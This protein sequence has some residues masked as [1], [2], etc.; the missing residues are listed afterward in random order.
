MIDFPTAFLGF[1]VCLLAWCSPALADHHASAAPLKPFTI[2][3]FEFPPLLHSTQSGAF[4]G[5]MGESVKL[6]CEEA[7]LDCRFR[8]VPLKRA[9]RELKENQADALITIDLGQLKECCVASK[10]ASPWSAGWFAS[11]TIERIPEKE[12]D[13]EEQ[14]LI[15][16][17]GMKSPYRF[18]PNLDKMAAEQKLF[19]SK[20][21]DISASVQ[22]FIHGRAPLLW[23]GEDFK[24]YFRKIDPT[25]QFS[26]TSKITIP[27]VVWARKERTA[28][29]ERLNS[30]F[31]RLVEKGL[32][33]V[34][35]L[36]EPSLMGQ[37]YQDAPFGK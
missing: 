5:T 11:P 32:L 16:V 1:L 15:V 6:L 26:F 21:V 28:A 37:R 19:V 35:N 24:W 3:S 13:L 36:L 31:D 33:G 20:A 34:N 8:V 30:A 25:A 12:A 14:S 18:S 17:M 29:M 9:Y 2:L 7:K 23:G 27:V 22:M 4:S 10:W